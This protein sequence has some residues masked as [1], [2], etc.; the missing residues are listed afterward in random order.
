[1]PW[2]LLLVRTIIVLHDVLVINEAVPAE[3]MRAPRACPARNVSKCPPQKI[4]SHMPPWIGRAEA[5]RTRHHHTHPS[6][7]SST[8]T[9][10]VVVAGPRDIAAP[11]ELGL[12]L[13]TYGD[14][15]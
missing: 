12:A 10:D 3:L 14:V 8:G 11:A 4:L 9:A 5:C 7:L 2:A 13:D 6:I 15:S 1:M